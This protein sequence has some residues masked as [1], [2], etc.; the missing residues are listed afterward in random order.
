MRSGWVSRYLPIT[1]LSFVE[2]FPFIY[3]HYLEINA[4]NISDDVMAECGRDNRLT[5]LFAKCYHHLNVRVIF[6]TQNV[7]HKGSEMWG[8]FFQ[9][10]I[11]IWLCLKTD[12][13]KAKSCI[14][15][16]NYTQVAQN[17]S[18]NCLRMRL[19]TFLYLLIDLKNQT[20]RKKRLS[21]ERRFNK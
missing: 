8:T 2:G 19:K 7:F 9:L 20:K 6:V 10:S 5:Y 12:A 13:I 18:K 11:I 14:Y 17:V 3:M 15:D 1:D 21:W 4:L 16:D